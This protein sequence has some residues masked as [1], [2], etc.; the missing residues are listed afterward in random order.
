MQVNLGKGMSME[1]RLWVQRSQ[2]SSSLATMLPSRTIKRMPGHLLLD[3]RP[4]W[5]IWPS[6]KSNECK[7]RRKKTRY[8]RSSWTTRLQSLITLRKRP[9]L[10]Q[11][12]G[13]GNQVSSS[14]PLSLVWLNKTKSDLI[15]VVPWEIDS[16]RHQPISTDKIINFWL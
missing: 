5:Q 2:S 10:R 12:L 7:S 16:D 9:H 11:P 6:E 13:R 14:C 8:S 3:P 1:H 15:R 4:R